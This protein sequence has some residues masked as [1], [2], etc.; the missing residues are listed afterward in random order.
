MKT[1]AI[2]LVTFILFCGYA[3][4]ES[5]SQVYEEYNQKKITGLAFAEDVEYH[6]A[7]S[8][9]E[10]EA[11]TLDLMEKTNRSREKVI[12]LYVSFSQTLA[13]CKE[14]S[15]VEE[16]IEGDE[17]FLI[18]EQKDIC[19]NTSSTPGTTKVKLINENGWKIDEVIRSL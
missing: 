8:R 14:I 9:K 10:V 7:R 4:A 1:R 2:T 17:A 15:L 11:K 13:K 3:K 12:E 5:P 6:T 18:Y 16:R 19:G